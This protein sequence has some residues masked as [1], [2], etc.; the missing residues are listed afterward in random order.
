[1]YGKYTEATAPPAF[2]GPRV[3]VKLQLDMHR[4]MTFQRRGKSASTLVKTRPQPLMDVPQSFATARTTTGANVFS[5]HRAKCTILGGSVLPTYWSVPHSGRRPARRVLRGPLLR[6]RQPGQHWHRWR[7]G[8]ATRESGSATPLPGPIKRSRITA[9]TAKR[10]F[11]GST[12]TNDGP[13]ALGY[14]S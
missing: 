1:M 6:R 8:G 14:V 10:P 7:F 9:R 2:H 5:P 12:H 4:V 11:A 3:K 13:L